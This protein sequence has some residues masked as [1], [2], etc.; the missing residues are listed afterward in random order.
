[1][2]TFNSQPDSRTRF[3]QLIRIARIIHRKLTS[4]PTAHLTG[5]RTTLIYLVDEFAEVDRLRKH[6]KFCEQHGH[7]AAGRLVQ[8]NALR[9]VEEIRT[10]L[11]HIEAHAKFPKSDSTE[12]ARNPA[13]TDIVR[14]L[15]QI[16][17]EFD[18][19]S[20]DE[21]AKKLTVV[22]D[23][24]TMKGVE[25]GAFDIVLNLGSLSVSSI[26]RSYTVEAQSPN[27]PSGN[28]RI[29]HP[30]INVDV[31]CAGEATAPIRRALLEGRVC[32]F[33][34]LVKG[35]IENYNPSSAYVMLE[36]WNGEL[37]H[38]CSD[39][40]NVNDLCFC[41][42]C[43]HDV[44]PD[45]SSSCEACDATRCN[46]CLSTCVRC[47]LY[48]CGACR[49]KCTECRQTCCNECLTDG[50]C[51][52]CAVSEEDGF[53]E[54]DSPDVNGITPA[55]NTTTEDARDET[56]SLQPSTPATQPV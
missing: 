9:F 10:R 11:A 53:D 23:N 28:N 26:S 25:L 2:H 46:G 21:K 36:H 50:I 37:C 8:E 55:P 44:C 51:T 12:T 18:D 19:W 39:R 56:P 22:S 4:D 14:E 24:I 3:E 15:Q 43:H 35:V 5:M 29:S 31:L 33:F 32:D 41:D 7:L 6:V 38:E 17:D 13:L 40:T 16:G 52:D 47:D 45:C 1:M 30:H 42:R 49:E 54:P 20:Y 27:C 48:V 34:L